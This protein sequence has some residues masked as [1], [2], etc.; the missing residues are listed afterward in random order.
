MARLHD[1]GLTEPFDS[2][3]LP[4]EEAG[5][6]LAWVFGTAAGR[7]AERAERAVE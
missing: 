7:P 3:R 5:G 2:H 6:Q 1:M 4:F